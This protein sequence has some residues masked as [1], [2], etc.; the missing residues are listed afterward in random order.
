MVVNIFRNVNDIVMFQKFLHSEVF[1][2]GMIWCLVIVSMLP[3]MEL[4]WEGLQMN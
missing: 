1:K 4:K 2:D 3:G